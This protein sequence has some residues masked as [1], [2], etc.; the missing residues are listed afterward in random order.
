MRVEYH[1]EAVDDI[2]NAIEYQRKQGPNQAERLQQDLIAAIA[3]IVG[4]PIRWPIWR[5]GPMRYYML[6]TFQYSVCYDFE[7]PDLIRVLIFRHHAQ[8]PS[9]GIKRR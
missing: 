6:D 8:K 5:R 1:D 3:G 7:P 2:F 4:A 9:Y